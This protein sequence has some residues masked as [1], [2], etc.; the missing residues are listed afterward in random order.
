MNLR[1]GF[2]RRGTKTCLVFRETSRIASH[3][4]DSK[5]PANKSRLPAG[6]AALRHKCFQSRACQ[7]EMA[8]LPTQTAKNH[9]SVCQD[10][11]VLIIP[12]TNETLKTSAALDSCEKQK[13]RQRLYSPWCRKL[14]G[15]F[16]NG[17]DWENQSKRSPV[18]SALQVKHLLCRSVQREEK[19][20]I[21]NRRE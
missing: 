17:L 14:K 7:P 3:Q 5:I 6:V 19:A 11:R 15:L 20:A 9:S 1:G 12:Q 10:W 16:L 18:I 8:R 21:N 4:P 2:T 13:I